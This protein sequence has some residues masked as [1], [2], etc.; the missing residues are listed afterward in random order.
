M[1]GRIARVVVGLL[2]LAGTVPNF[3]TAVGLL[4]VTGPAP[5]V[6]GFI[7][8]SGLGTAFGGWLLYGGIKPRRYVDNDGVV[9]EPSVSPP[10]GW[11]VRCCPPS[12]SLRVSSLSDQ[13]N[14][15]A[16]IVPFEKNDGVKQ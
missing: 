9:H 3:L 10:S 12:R 2:I 15:F 14:Q 16:F 1:I 7:L 13:A 8:G 6:F 4:V 5:R 11:A